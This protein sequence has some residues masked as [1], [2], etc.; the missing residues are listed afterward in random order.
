MKLCKD[1]KHAVMPHPLAQL[2]QYGHTA[3]V[4]QP[5]CGRPDAER[6]VVDGSLKT[7]CESA[8]RTITIY[9]TSNGIC[10]DAKLFEQA[11]PPAP[12]LGI[13]PYAPTPV[14]T[15][16]DRSFWERAKHWFM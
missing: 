13:K 7:T 4:Y 16:R 10:V 3:P 2:A 8:R 11:P 14:E 15:E 1:C 6:S 12:P 5:M 9:Q